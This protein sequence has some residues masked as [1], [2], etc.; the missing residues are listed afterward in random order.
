MTRSVALRLF[1]L[2]PALFLF[3]SLQAQIISG[4]VVDEKKHGISA[5]S[6]L[7]LRQ[8]DS[9]LVKSSLSDKEG[10]FMFR[11]VPPAKYILEITLV[12]HKRVYV[13]AEMTGKD[14]AMEPIVLSP[15]A[16]LL[17]EVKVIASKPFL[18]QKA[19]KLI[20][21][22]EASATMAGSTAL[23]ILQKVPGVLVRNDQVTMVGK[24]AP[25]ILID[26]RISQYTDISQLLRDLSAANIEKI[27]VISNPGA[28]YDAS[29]GAVINIILKKN[30]N[31][32]TNGSVYFI[33]G[34]GLYDRAAIHADRGFYRF[35]P[36][37]NINHRKGKLN[38]FGGF[39]FFHRN[40]FS[41]NEFDRIISPNR[42]F[43]EIY[44]PAKL[45]SYNFRLGADL[46]ASPK[47]TFG[48][49]A[50]AGFQDRTNE[51]SGVTHQL[52]AITNQ[53]LSQFRTQNNTYSNRNSLSANLNWKHQFDSLGKDLNM[54]LDFATFRLTNHGD[55]LTTLA[56]G[57]SYTTDQQIKNP[58]QYLV[59]KSDFTDPVTENLKLEAGAKAS[60]ATINNNLRFLQ[61][62]VLDA[63]KS[64]DFK[65]TERIS[66]LYSSISWEKNKWEFQGGL[67][68][69]QTIAKGI[70]QSLTVL[71]RN[72]W[73]LFPSAFVLR[74]IGKKM[75]GIASTAAG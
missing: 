31:L 45:S 53:S 37:F 1:L 74:K 15:D 12:S 22:V 47:N 54:D 64:T 2:S 14:L 58:V 13:Q 65:Y 26:G 67:R 3:H 5:A 69:E 42:F 40:W 51:A 63:N 57:S 27:E 29:G 7:L 21:N 44:E 61:R 50:K 32:G 30:A 19:D 66:A 48:F 35:N 55:I 41:Y 9:A 17:K 23:E 33:T 11:E 60:F 49:Y 43:Q 75:A 59:W 25:A 16:T 38:L 39:G 72:Y 71:N 28:R 20:V 8:S 70:S 18:E 56:N 46:Y 34:S 36:G 52:D 4:R 62:G 68:A 24:G 10:I 6:I 73:Q